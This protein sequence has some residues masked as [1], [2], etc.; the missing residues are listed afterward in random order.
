MTVDCTIFLIS[1]LN[2]QGQD[3]PRLIDLKDSGELEQAGTAVL[4][5]SKQDNTSIADKEYMNLE[6]AKNRNG[7]TGV[8]EFI[9]D[10][11]NQIL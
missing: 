10:K 7:R 9:Y 5:L 6:I 11:N 3:K 4:L 1:Q 8:V 2:R